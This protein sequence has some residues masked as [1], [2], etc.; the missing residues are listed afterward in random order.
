MS[1]T[2][3]ERLIASLRAR[4]TP[5]DGQTRPAAI[6]WTDPKREWLPL[7]D[8]LLERVDE[9]LVLGDYGPERR[10]GPAVWVRCIVDRTVEKPRLPE[11]RP[12][13]VYLPGV[14]RQELRAGEECP[15][16]LKPLV[17][18]LFRG[19]LWHHPNGGDWTVNAFLTSR[20]EA[21]SGRGRGS[22][23]GG[24][25]TTGAG[26]GGIDAGCST[27]R[28]ASGGRRLRSDACGR[29]HS[30]PPA[31]VGGFRRGAQTHGTERLVR[32]LCAL[33][34]GAGVRSGA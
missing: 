28:P 9:Y 32:L 15:D 27:R 14:A 16:R 31:V 18:L 5:P 22:D 4:D 17:E 33:P 2:V 29:C 8:L 3:L 10:T 23:H 7:V 11:D 34:G 20:S 25:A 30:R 24:R 1:D 6:V 26:R 13:I 12:P 21:R 19:A